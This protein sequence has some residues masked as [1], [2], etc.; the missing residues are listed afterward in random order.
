MYPHRT[1]EKYP[2]DAGSKLHE[3]VELAISI[4]EVK[5]NFERYGLLDDQVRFLKG[6]FKDA[7]HK[8]P[9]EKLAVLRLDGDLYE[10][11]MD[12]LVPLY[13][14]LS[15]GGYVIVDDY[16]AVVGCKKAIDEYRAEHGITDRI[17]AIDWGGIYWQKTQ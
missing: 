8:A 4:D 7:L 6:W 2:A 13:P 3:R 1:A 14:K 16:G 11:T 5:R 12:A 17:Q 9:I 10:S 15:I